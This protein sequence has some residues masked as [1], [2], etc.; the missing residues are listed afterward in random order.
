MTIETDTVTTMPHPKAQEA[1]TRSAMRMK[2]RE[3]CK[4]AIATHG[5]HFHVEGN[6]TFCF[7]TDKRN[8]IEVSSAIR[9]PGDKHDALMGRMVALERFANAQRMHLRM[10]KGYSSVRSFL[11][12]TFAL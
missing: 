6:Y 9:H 2:M 5:V 8:V 1:K 3:A 12:S 10:P 7:R 4:N 11:S